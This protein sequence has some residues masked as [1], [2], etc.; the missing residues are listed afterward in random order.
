MIRPELRE[1]VTQNIE[2]VPVPVV[3]QGIIDETLCYMLKERVIG[4]SPETLVLNPFESSSILM[5][6]RPRH[7]TKFEDLPLLERNGSVKH[8][9]LAVGVTYGSG[10]MT[11]KSK[12]DGADREFLSDGNHFIAIHIDIQNRIIN[13]MDSL[14]SQ[15]VSDFI[16][17]AAPAIAD[18][19]YGFHAR[20]I[21][22]IKRVSRQPPLSNDCAVHV[23]K[24]IAYAL[25][26]YHEV[27]AFMGLIVEPD[28]VG[29]DEFRGVFDAFYC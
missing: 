20:L 3:G 29:R 6:N 1:K 2:G 14:P 21:F 12:S 8:L 18:N 17:D 4:W 5:E 23:W 15:A 26:T 27:P 25:T 24:N 11:Y 10:R 7:S 28:D 16:C 9:F 13:L 19:I 22:N